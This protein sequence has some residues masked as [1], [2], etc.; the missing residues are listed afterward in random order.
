[1]RLTFS[2]SS[3]TQEISYRGNVSQRRLFF[4]VIPNVFECHYE[5]IETRTNCSKFPLELHK[6]DFQLARALSEVYYSKCA[7]IALNGCL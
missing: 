5:L 1:M 3:V 7:E 2:V 4:P 6:R